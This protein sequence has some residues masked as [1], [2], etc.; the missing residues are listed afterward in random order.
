MTCADCGHEIRMNDV[1]EKPLQ[2][3]TGMLKHIAAH[4]ASRAFA[5][6]ERVIGSEPTGAVVASSSLS[7]PSAEQ[8]HLSDPILAASSLATIVGTPIVNDSLVKD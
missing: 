7:T 5:T 3:A 1:C 2:S 8:A 6:A 4:N